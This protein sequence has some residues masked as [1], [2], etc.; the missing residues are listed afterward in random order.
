MFNLFN[1]TYYDDKG[2]E[3]YINNSSTTSGL[4]DDK[5]D[6]TLKENQF[7]QTLYL[8]DYHEDT[9]YLEPVF[10]SIYKVDNPIEIKIK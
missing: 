9:V 3:Y 1:G 7:I 2:N 5:G 10:T 4:Y 8:T 6:N